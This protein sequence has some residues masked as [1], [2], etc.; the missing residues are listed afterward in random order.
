MFLDSIIDEKTCLFEMQTFLNN[1]RASE[2]EVQTFFFKIKISKKI[3]IFN[4]FHKKEAFKCLKKKHQNQKM[5]TLFFL[6]YVNNILSIK[7]K[8]I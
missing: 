3:I 5:L 7:L 4:E 2:F 6:T 1:Q 8:M